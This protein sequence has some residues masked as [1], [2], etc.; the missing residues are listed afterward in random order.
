MITWLALSIGLTIT[1]GIGYQIMRPNS[2]R[3]L[4]KTIKMKIVS[5]SIQKGS[6]SLTEED[7]NRWRQLVQICEKDKMIFDEEIPPLYER[8]ENEIN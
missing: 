4:L 7:K 5:K 1:I 3:N 2:F 8:T 6:I